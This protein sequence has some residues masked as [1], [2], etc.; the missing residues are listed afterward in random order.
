ML[1]ETPKTAENMQGDI[2]IGL[3]FL[4]AALTGIHRHRKAEENSDD[5]ALGIS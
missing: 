2:H 1:F 3:C 4:Q 5:R